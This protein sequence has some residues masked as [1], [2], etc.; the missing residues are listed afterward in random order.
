MENAAQERLLQSVIDKKVYSEKIVNHD[1]DL[2]KWNVKALYKD[3]L[4]VKLLDEPDADL[5]KKGS[6]F[7]K[8]NTVKGPYR[9]G[10]V[11]M[12][13]PDTVNAKTGDKVIIPQMTGQPGYRSYE[14]YKTW[15]V[16][17]DAVMAVLEFDGDDVAMQQDIEDQLL[18]SI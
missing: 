8:I 16:K 5:L 18:L 7:V 14:G 10:E 4:W 17:E 11:I 2:T 13:G 15:F 9:L 1:I 12:T 6:L 3:T